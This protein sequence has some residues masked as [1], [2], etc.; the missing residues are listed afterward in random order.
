MAQGGGQMGD[1]V[2]QGCSSGSAFGRGHPNSPVTLAIPRVSVSP[3]S[4][5]ETSAGTNRSA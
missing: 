5:Y 3:R 4:Q 2:H 1:G